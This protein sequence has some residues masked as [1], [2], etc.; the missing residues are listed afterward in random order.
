[1]VI[2]DVIRE[3]MYQQGKSIKDIYAVT[4]LDYETIYNIVEKDFNP[5]PKD[6]DII[7]RALGESLEIILKLY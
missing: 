7:L 3:L 5:K 1:M 6:A 4:E 2:N